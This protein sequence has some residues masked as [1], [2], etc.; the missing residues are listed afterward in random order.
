MIKVRCANCKKEFY[1]NGNDMCSVG[2]RVSQFHK[3]IHECYC[4]ECTR[5]QRLDTA[6]GIKK[7][8]YRKVEDVEPE[9]VKF[10]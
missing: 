3:K 1:C 5:K 6:K 8:G 9:M 2:I 4:E 10:T 7:C